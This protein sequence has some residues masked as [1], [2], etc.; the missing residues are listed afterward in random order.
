MSVRSQ[1]QTGW[2]LFLHFIAPSATGL[3]VY[4]IVGLLLIGAHLLYMSVSGTAYPASFNDTLLMGY[5]N[6]VIQPLA[7]ITNSSAANNMITIVLWGTAGLIV[8]EGIRFTISAVSDLRDAN[9]DVAHPRHG[10]LVSH[11]LE[12]RI[13]ARL[14]WQLLVGIFMVASTLVSARLVHFCLANDERIMKS[15]ALDKGLL[16][17]GATL[18]VWVVIFHA[19]VVLLRTYMLRT[20]LFGEILY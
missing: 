12:R 2:R 17:F 4:F 15:A 16:L 1:Q 19:Y 5:A 11:P 3:V 9:N 14:G 7:T 10:V 20:R 13:I 18:L 6:L 8:Y